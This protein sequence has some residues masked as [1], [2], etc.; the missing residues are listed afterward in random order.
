MC[1]IK[2]SD[3][4]HM[5]Y[6]ASHPLIDRDFLGLGNTRIKVAQTARTIYGKE[7]LIVTFLL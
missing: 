2:I 4:V 5:F 6:V 3:N 1:A 7:F